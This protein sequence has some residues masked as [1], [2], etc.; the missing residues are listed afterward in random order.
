MKSSHAEK[1]Q[2]VWESQTNGTTQRKQKTSPARTSSSHTQEDFVVRTGDVGGVKSCW[3][4]TDAQPISI[5][6]FELW[7]TL[8]AIAAIFACG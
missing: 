7:A 5:Q 8:S 6:L 1:A 2:R 3:G 4:E